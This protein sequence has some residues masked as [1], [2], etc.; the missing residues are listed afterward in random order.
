MGTEAVIYS[1]VKLATREG[2]FCPK[3]APIIVIYYIQVSFTGL[4]IWGVGS[5]E[6]CAKIK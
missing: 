2:P 4:S 6:G 5:L 3:L 1:V